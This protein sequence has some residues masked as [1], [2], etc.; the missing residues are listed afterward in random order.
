MDSCAQ[1]LGGCPRIRKPVRRD[2]RFEQ[3]GECLPGRSI[4]LLK[5]FS[6]GLFYEMPANC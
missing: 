1:V 6:V 3:I 4:L 5:D 2:F